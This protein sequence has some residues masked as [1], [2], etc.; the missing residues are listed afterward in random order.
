MAY[1]ARWRLKLAAEI[2]QSTDDSARKSPL[3]WATSQKLDLI[4]LSSVSSVALPLNSVANTK[5]SHLQVMNLISQEGPLIKQ[6]ET[7]G[8]AIVKYR[9]NVDKIL[10]M[11][12]P[13]VLHDC[14]YKECL[15]DLSVASACARRE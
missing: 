10:Q 8:L 7:Y 5:R 14:C 6:R 11:P 3:Q 13:P 12:P 9:L 2:L 15:V 1:L 4:V